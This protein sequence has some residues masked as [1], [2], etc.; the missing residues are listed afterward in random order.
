MP[1]AFILALIPEGGATQLWQCLP[2][3]IT[4][5]PCNCSLTG[6]CDYAQEQGTPWCLFCRPGNVDQYGRCHCPCRS[7][8]PEDDGWSESDRARTCVHPSSSIEKKTQIQH[9]EERWR[10]LHRRLRRFSKKRQTVNRL[11]ACM[12]C[13]FEGPCSNFR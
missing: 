7:C 2:G 12:L 4:G 6:S 8:D 10:W 3:D 9:G 13:C 5:G 11:I 1:P